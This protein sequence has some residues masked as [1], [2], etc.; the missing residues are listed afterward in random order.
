MRDKRIQMIIYIVIGT[1]LMGAVPV[2]FFWCWRPYNLSG[3]YLYRETQAVPTL[4]PNQKKA[5]DLARPALRSKLGIRQFREYSY[6]WTGVLPD[7]ED[8]NIYAVWFDT[9][10]VT[11]SDRR[12]RVDISQAKIIQIDLIGYAGSVERRQRSPGAVDI[13]QFKGRWQADDGRRLEFDTELIEREGDVLGATDM[14][15]G[16]EY[17]EY[18]GTELIDHGLWTIDEKNRL[19]FSSSRTGR[20]KVYDHY[21]VDDEALTFSRESTVYTFKRITK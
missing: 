4:N 2:Y 3:Q 15:Y 10:R 5:L 9:I 16:S 1:I 13:E 14:V 11:D 19:V 18:Q 21:S 6:G 20:L 8:A 7:P 17:R 12:I